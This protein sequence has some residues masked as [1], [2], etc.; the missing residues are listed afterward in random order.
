MPN[1]V[2]AENT[3]NAT[4]A[5]EARRPETGEY[6][7]DAH[8]IKRK[9]RSPRPPPPPSQPAVFTRKTV[10]TQQAPAAAS[11]ESAEALNIN[12]PGKRGWT[13]DEIGREV[14]SPPIN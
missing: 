3:S 4:T 7:S 11:R 1:S 9:P 14:P 12:I 8:A 2:D 13:P 6:A 10:P 5:R